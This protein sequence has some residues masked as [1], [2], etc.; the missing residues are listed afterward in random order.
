MDFCCF[1]TP[2]LWYFVM[3]AQETRVHCLIKEITSYFS[4]LIVLIKNNW[5]IFASYFP[6]QVPV[7][8]LFD[9]GSQ[10]GY[11]RILKCWA[12]V[13]GRNAESLHTGPFSVVFFVTTTVVEKHINCQHPRN[14]SDTPFFHVDILLVILVVASVKCSGNAFSCEW[15]LTSVSSL[16]GL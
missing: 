11:K 15:N 8:L 9:V 2:S 12:K 1:K 7:I 5:W 4:F 16:A 13:M 3:A 10:L 6:L 14:P